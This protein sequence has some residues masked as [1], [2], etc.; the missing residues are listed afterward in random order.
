VGFA[1]EVT[2]AI[3]KAGP[4]SSGRISST[5]TRSEAASSARRY[6]STWPQS[7]SLRSSPGTNPRT[8]S[9]RGRPEP[10]GA[11]GRGAPPPRARVP[12]RAAACG[13]RGSGRTWPAYSTTGGGLGGHYALL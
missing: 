7:A 11:W 3:T 13:P 2:V 10:Q 1:S 6:A 5:L 8:D 9:G 12:T 4:R